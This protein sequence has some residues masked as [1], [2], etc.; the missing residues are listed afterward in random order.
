MTL[1]LSLIKFIHIYVNFVLVFC[2]TPQFGPTILYGVKLLL[3]FS[4]SQGQVKGIFS[5]EFNIKI[6]ETYICLYVFL[7]DGVNI[8]ITPLPLDFLRNG[9]F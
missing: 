9:L 7:K 1:P 4:T 8:V 5:K 6:K 3:L 2:S